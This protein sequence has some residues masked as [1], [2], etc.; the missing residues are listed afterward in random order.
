MKQVE[1]VLYL[2]G[3]H[4][5]G[6]T[7][8]KLDHYEEGT[9]TPTIDRLSGSPTTATYSY[10]TGKYTRIGNVV[11]VYFDLNITALG[12]GAGSCNCWSSIC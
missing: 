2:I 5:T 10:N 6:A 7:S 8:D 9:W 12:G 1:Q 11:T 3:K 4:K